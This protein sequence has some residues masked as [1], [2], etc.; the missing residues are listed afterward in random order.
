MLIRII[1]LDDMLEHIT[2][3]NFISHEDTSIPFSE[4]V[5]IFIGKNGAGKSSVI[6]AITYALYGKHA[7]GN[8]A[9]IV[10]NNT[11]GGS[12]TLRFSSNGRVYEV[13]RAYNVNGSS[14]V[15]NIKEDG[16]LVASGDKSIDGVSKRIETI[17][18][19]GYN[20]ISIATII[21]QGELDAIIDLKPREIKELINRLIELDKLD[22]AYQEFRDVLDNFRMRLKK[23][24]GYDITD[25]DKIEE[26][27][28]A[29]IHRKRELERA[30][31]NIEE[32][33][34][35]KEEE[36]R[37]I[38]E[39]IKKY[40][41]LKRK[42]D[43]YIVKREELY[44][45]LKREKLRYNDEYK[46]KLK[47]IEQGYEFLNM[48]KKRNEIENRY[49]ELVELEKISIKFNHLN[50][51]L[52]IL[53]RRREDYEHEINEIRDKIRKYELIDEPEYNYKQITDLLISTK[54]ELDKINRSIGEIKAKLDDYE[55]IKE[56]GICPTCDRSI[57]NASIDSKINEKF[58]ELHK[59]EYRRVEL[60][61]R[62]E[63]LEELKEVRRRYDEGKDELEELYKRFEK[64]E[65]DYANMIKQYE[66][67]EK[68]LAL[69]KKSNID[70]KEKIELEKKIRK[71]H[72]I[73]GWL[74]ASDII[75]IDG[76]KRLEE[77][78]AE[79][80]KTI[81]L[82]DAM[83]KVGI[84]DLA[85]DAYTRELIDVI[86][87]LEK[88]SKNYDRKEHQNLIDKH[89]KLYSKIRTLT[90]DQG[91]L[92]ANLDEICR[93]IEEFESAK[94]VLEKAYRYM[95]LYEQIRDDIYHKKLPL[96]LRSWA[97]EY[98]SD[99]ASEYLRIFDIGISSIQLKEEKNNIKIRCYGSSDLV[100]INS[101][102]GGE[103]IAVALALRFAIA[104]FKGRENID[105]IILDEPTTHLDQERRRALVKLIA[106]LAGY[107]GLIRQII[108]ITHD[109]EIFEDAEVDNIVRFEKLGSISVTSIER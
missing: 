80:R 22:K 55:I 39:S 63:E 107:Q 34:L 41:E 12:V 90:F 24:H 57:S 52:T 13:F 56:K 84:E 48:I 103:K 54:S 17:L 11:N 33:L 86:K 105:F 70:M 47:M 30:L 38:E 91:R 18:G 78:V 61:S 73:E 40:E 71:I 60:K 10:R 45:H 28:D 36:K 7:R 46:T 102:S 14:K 27:L 6:D 3:K 26:E 59:L 79:I 9:N 35:E 42:Y 64:L 21:K 77:Q 106:K 82:L 67:I 20:D 51:S 8:N 68:E 108:M 83:D 66:E 4:G 75:D 69:L 81:E 53:K 97:F 43:Q 31:Q 29:N 109:A 93:K 23:E 92:K 16:R 89:N 15:V 50:R 101:M 85:I 32:E 5:N 99:K 74:E 100:D 94:Q 95:K 37:N 96:E 19:L 62:E 65:R 2:L 104:S 49:K 76:I 98:I 88:E 58:E 25:L 44:R 1:G 87:R 72:Q